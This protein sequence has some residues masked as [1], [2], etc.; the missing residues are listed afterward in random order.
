MIFGT[1][2]FVAVFDEKP[3]WFAGPRVVGMHAHEGPAA[4]HLLTL[5]VELEVAFGESAIDVGI[6]LYRFPLA[7]IPEHHGS[8]AVLAL[9]DCA[10]EVAVF[11]GVVFYLDGEALVGGEIAR[12]FGDGPAFQHA[13]PRKPKIIVEARGGMFL[14]DEGQRAALCSSLDRALV[15]AGL[16]GDVEVPHLPV[17]SQLIFQRLGWIF[18]ARGGL[19]HGYAALRERLRDFTSVGPFFEEREVEREAEGFAC[20]GALLVSLTLRLRASM[21]LMTLARGLD[22]ATG[23]GDSVRLASMSSRSAAS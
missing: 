18:F 4:M 1:R 17:T 20:F 14:N 2:E 12:S 16:G 3:V 23:R 8:P 11:D 5:E 7:E 10:F 22:S 13:I 19:C 21:R 9:G 6:I 15:S